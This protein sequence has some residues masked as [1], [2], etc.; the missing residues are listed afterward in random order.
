MEITE[1]FY[2]KKYFII[3]SLFSFPSFRLQ[4]F[5]F[6]LLFFYYYYFLRII[7]SMLIFISILPFLFLSFRNADQPQL[8]KA[9]RTVKE[10][11]SETA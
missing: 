2:F 5:P 4:Y 1:N 7:S 8:F 11:R 10:H 3:S 6:P 9:D